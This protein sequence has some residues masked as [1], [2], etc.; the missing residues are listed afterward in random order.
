[1]QSL[2]DDPPPGL[3]TKPPLAPRHALTPAQCRLAEHLASGLTNRQIALALG[4][5]E[6][7][8]RNQVTALYARLGVRNRAGAAA[9]WVGLRI[10]EQGGGV[11]IGTFGP[12]AE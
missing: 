9:V 1:M 10:R 6:K 2:L 12:L 11:Q 4:R 3:V 5:S 8:V 7:T